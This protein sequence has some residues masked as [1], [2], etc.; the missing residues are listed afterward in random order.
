[1]RGNRG[2]QIGERAQLLHLARARDGQQTRH[3]ELAILA[4]VPKHDL[5]PLHNAPFILPA[6][7]TLARFTI[8]GTRSSGAACPST[9]SSSVVASAWPFAE[10]PTAPVR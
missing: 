9:T 1:M 6:S 7:V 8:V 5:A 10:C 4:P 3:R 2:R